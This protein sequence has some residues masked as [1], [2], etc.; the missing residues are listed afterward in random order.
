MWLPP[1][2]ISATSIWT[3]LAAR[4]GTS[5]PSTTAP[6]ASNSPG[7]DPGGPPRCLLL[8][9]EELQ[10]PLP[11]GEGV[12]LI[13]GTT[14]SGKSVCVNSILTCFLLHNT[15]DDL[16]LI[17]VDPKRV[18]LTSYNGVP[19][20]LAPVVVEIDRVIGAL[21]WMT[22]EMDKRYHMFAQVGARNITDYNARMKLQGTKKL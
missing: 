7:A 20:L 3:R 9:P 14:G 18:E 2:R 5:K 8:T 21:Q 4:Y 11:H 17:L 13:A 6:P 10:P 19:H 22:R 1:A 15:P 12:L 16:R